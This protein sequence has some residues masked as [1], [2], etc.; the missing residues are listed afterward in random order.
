[1]R[2]HTIKKGFARATNRAIIVGDVFVLDV[3][4]AAAEL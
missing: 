2:S 4:G 1:M 3:D